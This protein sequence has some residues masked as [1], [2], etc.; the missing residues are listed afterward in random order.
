MNKSEQLERI[1]FFAQQSCVSVSI[2]EIDAYFS[3]GNAKNK[4]DKLERICFFAQQS[5]ISLEELDAYFSLR[6]AKKILPGMYVYADGLVSS[7]IIPNRQIKA[8]VGYIEDKTVYAVCL[9]VKRLPWSDS[10][11]FYVEETRMMSNGKEATKKI[12]ETAWAQGK[13]AEAA[14]WCHDYAQDGVKQG[15]AFLPSLDELKRLSFY[16][17]VI[18]DSLRR[19]KAALLKQGFYWSSIESNR[20]MAKSLYMIGRDE[21]DDCCKF[22]WHYVRPVISFEL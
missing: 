6:D 12:L 16:R 2:K 21:G 22:L 19:L 17:G 3:S 13:K 1:Y 7:E 20:N 18:N 5:G 9:Q 15:E 11:S 14:Q 4:R 10:I 8:V